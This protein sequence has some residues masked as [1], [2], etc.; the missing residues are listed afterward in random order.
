[1]T[2]AGSIIG[3]AQYLSPEQ[4]RGAPVDQRSD[5]YSVGVLLYELL[6][7]GV[8]F[9]GDTPVEIA[10]K[11]LSAVPEPP[12][13]KRAEVPRGLDL[14]VVRALAKDPEDRFQSAEEMDAE[15]ARIEQGFRVSDETATRPPPCSPVRGS[16]TT[17]VRNAARRH[18]RRVRVLRR[19]G[20]YPAAGEEAAEMAMA[21][22]GAGARRDSGA[23]LVPGR[24]AVDA[25]RAELRPGPVGGGIVEPWR[26]RS[27]TRPASATR[28]STAEH[29]RPKGKVIQQN[30]GPGEQIPQGNK[31]T[32]VV[33]QGPPQVS[34]PNVVG[35][36]QSEAEGLLQ[37]RN[38]QAD[39]H[40]VPNDQP[41]GTVVAQSPSADTTV[42][43]N[44]VVRINVASGPQP[45]GIPDVVGQSYSD[46]LA[47]LQSLGF[48]VRRQDVASN[49]PAETVLAEIP[50]ANSVAPQ[51]STVTLKV[52]RGP[53]D[54][55]RP[56]RHRPRP[57][58]GDGDADLGGIPGRG[59]AA[60]HDRSGAGRR[61]ARAEP[62]RRQAV[63]RG[64]DDHH[65]RRSPHRAD[66][67][68]A[69]TT[70]TPTTPTTTEPTTTITP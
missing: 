55:R 35:M 1:M 37:S 21:T 15:L 16:T 42:D 20:G 24:P 11:H 8:P 27:S 13:K 43:V 54:H 9:T 48:A 67:H 6:T 19:T 68:R 49:E 62:G 57:G 12:S 29:R 7:G 58:H 44:T 10:M 56:G 63:D 65:R 70:T 45:V 14:A 46:A 33:S 69:D 39:V 51:G 23:R 47:K 22:R 53:T 40:T 59:P 64:L 60:R 30:P 4:A 26:S 41:E 32:I 31:V 3:T 61:R 52:S 17:A 2:E 18:D 66:D 5:I 50:S 28:S 38:L 36:S 25:P 34:V